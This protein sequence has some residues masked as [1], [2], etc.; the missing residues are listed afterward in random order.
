MKK[1]TTPD[2]G[3]R[4]YEEIVEQIQ[5]LIL[6]GE[7]KAGDRLPPERTL[8]Q[9][10]K[11]SR[12]CVREALRALTEKKLLESRRGDGTYICSPDD[13]ALVSSLAQAIQVQQNRLRDIFEFRQIIEPQIAALAA[14]HITPDELSRLKILVFEQERKNFAEE[15]MAEL[16]MEFHLLLAEA[17]RNMVLLEV[18]KLLNSILLETR[19]EFLQ[20]EA[21]RTASVRSHID[22]INSLEKH[23]EDAAC[24]AMQ[25]HLQKVKQTVYGDA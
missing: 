4:L 1:E 10:F 3:K 24:R 15:D 14:R 2:Q 19:S 8:A 5:Q 20:S 6:R 16:D 23:D 21:R 13:S 22:I 18:V 11:V 9:T 25:N 7:L 12:N 17:A